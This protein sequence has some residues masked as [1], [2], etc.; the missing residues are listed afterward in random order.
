MR[1][2]FRPR[3]VAIFL[4]SV[5][6]AVPGSALATE[7]ASVSSPTA[8][9]SP[10]TAQSVDNATSPA[11]PTADASSS[12]T[13]SVAPTPDSSPSTSATTTTEPS[14]PATVLQTATVANVSV[15]I[16]TGW[17]TVDLSA[18]PTACVRFDKHAVYV[19]T[20]GP[21]QDCPAIVAGR[22]A[23]IL[24]QPLPSELPFGTVILIPGTTV[25]PSPEQILAGEIVA[26][27]DG[28]DVLVTATFG[29]DVGEAVAALKTVSVAAARVQSRGLVVPTSFLATAALADPPPLDRT[30]TWH[31]GPGFD[32][33]T[34]PALSTMQAWLASPYRAIGVYIGG[35]LRGCAQPN[36][37]SSWV[38]SV[39]TLGWT[40]QPIYVGVQAPCSNFT[41]KITY[42]QEWNQG[43]D[44]ALD[45]VSRARALGIGAGSDIY[46]DMEGYTVGT[47]CSGSVRAF[48]S[49]WTDTLHYNGYSSGVYS[50]LAS[51]IADLAIGAGQPGFV[52]PDK[53]WIARWN[54]VPDVYGDAPYV[55]DDQWS[56]YQRIKQ[57][58]GGH[59]E[60]FG[61]VTINID[62]DILDT[63]PNQG[64]PL[65]QF[66]SATA[67]PS[68]VTANGW[69]IDPDTNASIMVQMY[70]DGAT[71]ALTW[72]NQNRTDIGDA[73]PAAG[74]AHGYSLTMS[75]PAGWHTVCLY[76]INTGPG[77]S[78]PLGCRTINVLSSNPFGQFDSA[79]AGP[80][81]VTANGWAIDP[82]T[83]ASIMVQMY[84]DGAT[85]ALTWAN[86]NRTDI[87]D[88]FPAAGP[89]HGYS[90]TMS[91]PAGWH[92][93]CLYA[94]NTGP[95]TSSPLGC[96]TINVLSSN[97]FG[98]FDSATAGPSTVT[99]NGWAIDPDTNASIMVQMY[100]DGAT[101]ALTWANQNRT[102]IGD[103]FPAAG[104]AHGYSLTMSTPAGWHT[105]CLYAINTGPG[106]SSPLGCRTINVP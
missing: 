33:C 1:Q 4:L 36:L 31:H 13:V 68:T 88:A 98:Q 11:T 50:S 10:T 12:P 48:L 52:A 95:G 70:I 89:A 24:L 22:I 69:A 18:D 67:G 81:T 76:A 35:A 73:F 90:L 55:R 17:P 25:A 63:D 72:A 101:N 57:Y 38:R 103:A 62:N 51:G 26:R 75:T 29:A 85:N 83:N 87:G 44:A 39:A 74:P 61:G 43:R 2:R 21:A 15:D 30:F 23:A 9:T 97:P 54:G 46:Y 7:P 20:P 82:D 27:V 8:E 64:N 5:A 104:P 19:G 47:Q 92:T 93:V 77:T 94:I 34:A 49:S 66:D 14:P 58:R 6:A 105:V 80:S 99:A 56:P 100:I 37:T 42:G 86:Q 91:T 28:S 102:D 53:I 65:G 16:P 60:T 78:S 41:S 96:R 3:R 32:A 59:N 71:N 84:I 79:T 40:A 106:T 45:A